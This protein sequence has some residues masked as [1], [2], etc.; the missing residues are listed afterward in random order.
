MSAPFDNFLSSVRNYTVEHD[1]SKELIQLWMNKKMSK[2]S[3]DPDKFNAC[4]FDYINA[5]L[6]EGNNGTPILTDKRNNFSVS[7]ALNVLYLDGDYLFKDNVNE[8][9]YESIAISIMNDHIRT[10]QATLKAITTNPQVLYTFMFIPASFKDRKGGH[11]VFMILDRSISKMERKDI[12]TKEF[13]AAVKSNMQLVKTLKQYTTVDTSDDGWIS[14]LFDKQPIEN[15]NPLLLFGQ[16]SDESRQYKLYKHDFKCTSVNDF[17][18]I[19][20]IRH[21]N[22]LIVTTDIVDSSL[23]MSPT[24]KS[25][26]NDPEL[27]SH[28]KTSMES[29]LKELDDI[30]VDDT[31]F[32]I[33]YGSNNDNELYNKFGSNVFMTLKFVKSLAYLA[34]NHA[35]FNIFKNHDERLFWFILPLL[36][37]LYANVIVR[38]N[39]D[40][41]DSAAIELC[42]LTTNALLPIL[43]RT[44]ND[45]DDPTHRDE[46]NSCYV[47]VRDMMNIARSYIAPKIK[48]CWFIYKSLTPKERKRIPVKI[49]AKD[50]LNDDPTSINFTTHDVSRARNAIQSLFMAWFG[51]VKTKVLEYISTEIEPFVEQKT[52]E[53]GSPNPRAGITFDD[54]L[55][56]N[57]TNENKFYVKVMSIWIKMLLFVTFVDSES[58]DST[59]QQIC[60]T[61]LKYY[62][63]CKTDGAV[64]DMYIYNIRQTLNLKAYPY[65]Q[66]IR[67]TGDN[68]KHWI[69]SFYI[70]HIKRELDNTNKYDLNNFLSTLASVEFTIKENDQRKLKGYDD[71]STGITKLYNCIMTTFSVGSGCSNPPTELNITISNVFPCRNGILKWHHD[72]TYEF[73]KN[74]KD[75]CV[76]GFTNVTFDEHYDTNPDTNY[77]YKQVQDMWKRTFPIEED[78]IYMKYMIS[79]L[80]TGEGL[81]DQFL[82][83]YGTGGDGKTTFCSFVQ[84]MLGIVSTPITTSAVDDRGINCV[85]TNPKGLAGSMK[86]ETILT[87][88]AGT[89]DEGGK[90]ELKGARFCTIQEPDKGLSNNMINCS[91][92]KELLSGS[93]INARHIRGAS[94]TFTPN[95]LIILQTN[96]LPGYTEDSDAT[97]RRFV[98]LPMQSKFTTNTNKY[99]MR[100]LRYVYDADPIFA[101]AILNDNRYWDALFMTLLPYCQDLYRRKWITISNIQRPTSVRKTTEN[102]FTS[103]SGLLGYLNRHFK[104]SNG[105][106]IC[107]KDAIDK[108]LNVNRQYIRDR[109]GK[110][111]LTGVNENEQR[112][113]IMQQFGVKYHSDIY[114]LRPEFYISKACKRVNPK[115]AKDILSKIPYNNNKDIVTAYFDEYAVSS[116]ANSRTIFLDDLYIIGYKLED[117]DD[118][119][120]LDINIDSTDE[121]TVKQTKDEHSEDTY[122][123]D[124]DIDNDVLVELDM[125]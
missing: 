88:K 24:L 18:G 3:V 61:F 60:S 86:T 22:D 77:I 125:H 102:S 43:K 66:W 63:W 21:T 17:V 7:K 27:K 35:L 70:N 8:D 120:S 117:D 109:N 15:A 104:R 118:N 54:Y 36:K 79:S 72:G 93:T 12:I 108:L 119:I 14:S 42:V 73:S 33:D 97:R 5:K 96:T 4:Y 59:I 112:S 100:A 32:N 16:K 110:K 76:N 10:W 95:A 87:S 55:N 68:I 91:V 71:I 80:L 56:I 85:I 67:D 62:V 1:S 28:D 48:N 111:F 19:I 51:C 83:L 38:N 34:P 40:I 53:R 101:N 107:V 106:C 23:L 124:D 115:V 122:D 46:F 57:Y 75:I 98:I 84:A 39:E 64:K 49:S 31:K 29:M 113:E 103:A 30:N 99:H 92:V 81:K 123:E 89:H 65:N 94:E 116:Q 45:V 13:E 105:Y 74:N 26:L 25:L 52:I 58:T 41:T 44:V 2:F 90:I 37:F 69:K 121:N 114:L 9:A 82:V 6:Q 20:P 47:N 78:R 11:H 50:A